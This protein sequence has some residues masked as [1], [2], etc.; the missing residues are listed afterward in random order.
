M[1]AHVRVVPTR[2]KALVAILFAALFFFG[3]QAPAAHASAE[4]DLTVAVTTKTGST[5]SG[6]N[7][8]AFPVVLRAAIDDPVQGVAVSGRPGQF[9]FT[10]LD[11]G[12]DYAIWFDAPS[13]AT[14]AFDQF[15]GGVTWIEDATYR[16]WAAGDHTLAVSLATNTNITGKVT[17]ASGTALSNVV[18]YPYRFDGSDWYLI[19]DSTC[20]GCVVSAKTNSVGTFVLRNLEP[21]SYRLEFAP[22][23][24][25]GYLTEFSG[26][27]LSLD[28]ATAIYAGLGTTS[29]VNASLLTGG[30]ITGKVTYQYLGE[31]YYA[32]GVTAVAYP[33][34]GGQVDTSMLYTS[35]ATGVSGSWTIPG[36]PPGSYVVNF[37]DT[38]YGTLEDFW[39]QNAQYASSATPLHIV[40][41]GSVNAGSTY[42]PDEFD[43]NPVHIHVQSSSTAADIEGAR[44]TVRAQDSAFSWEG[45]T[46]VSGAVSIPRIVPNGDFNVAV[47]ARDDQGVA[48]HHPSITVQDSASGPGTGWTILLAAASPFQWTSNP[49]VAESATKAGTTYDLTVPTT[50]MND[51]TG[52]ETPTY[53]TIQWLRDGKPIFGATGTTYQS[54][55]ADVGSILSVLVRAYGYGYPSIA[56]VATIGQ[57]TPGD[58]PINVV[59]PSISAPPVVAP[60]ATLSAN[61][62]TWNQSGLR[63]SFQWL[64]D[65]AVIPGETSRRYVLSPLDAV[66]NIKLEVTATRPG[67]GITTTTTTPI[68]VTKLPALKQTTTS[69]LTKPTT[70]IPVGSLS[71]KITS[72]VWTPAASSYTYQWLIDGDPFGPPTTGASATMVCDTVTQCQPEKVIQVRVTALRTGYADG[73]KTSVVRKGTLTPLIDTDGFA[74]ISTA[75]GVPLLATD[76][77]GVGRVLTATPPVL[78]WS[79]LA[80]GT[81]TVAYQWQSS[82]NNGVTWSNISGATKSTYAVK[83]DVL[84]RRVQVRLTVS[85][86]NYAS[87]VTFADA[88][89]ARLK[90]DLMGVTYPTL[91]INGS[92]DVTTTKWV[93]LVGNWPLSGVTQKYQWFSCAPTAASCS[94]TSSANPDWKPIAGATATSFTPPL[95]LQDHKLL[96]RV[97]GSKSGYQSRELRS[98]ALLLGPRDDTWMLATP[99]ISS[100]LVAGKAAIGR[101]LTGKPG[102]V[103]QPVTARVYRWETCVVCDGSDWTPIPGATSTTY[104]PT[105][106]LLTAYPSGKIRF[107]D[108]VDQP[109]PGVVGNSPVYPLVA[110]TFAPTSAPTVSGTTT[111]TVGP[112]TWPAATLADGTFQT[113]YQ[114]YNGTTTT[115]SGTN[116]LVSPALSANPVWVK[117]TATREG[118]TPLIYRLVARKGT[119]SLAPPALSGAVYGDTFQLAG[120]LPVPVTE[121]PPTL[122]YQWYSGSTAITGQTKATFMPSTS[123]VGKALKLRISVSS[124]FYNAYTVYSQAVT[125]A[126]HPASTPTPTIVSSTPGVYKPGAKLTAA[127]TGTPSGSTFTY[128]WQRS[129]DGVTWTNITTSSSYILTTSDPTKLIRVVVVAKKAGWVTSAAVP[130][131]A[132]TVAYTGTLA[133]VGPLKINGSGAVGSALS[134]APIWNTTGVT[135]TYKWLRNGVIL[136]GVTGTTFTPLSSS[137]G[138]EID[139]V[140]TASKPGYQTLAFTSNTVKVGE[141]VGPV[142]TSTPLT[143]SPSIAHQGMPVTVASAWS[144]DGVTLTYEWAA[145]SAPATILGT[146]PTFIPPDDI[147]Y[148][149]TVTATK[150]GYTTGTISRTVVVQP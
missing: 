60:G 140:A 89:I 44:V 122:K 123:Y 138:D 125:L 26:N 80:P 96:V 103:D 55:G 126:L 86:T 10:G 50:T 136:P 88:G 41:T 137:I 74:S 79:G 116:T 21:G 128:V 82:T 142:L 131:L 4:V 73:V 149:V 67:F 139:V 144:A 19:S 119:L 120:P 71:Y 37:V 65:D 66:H 43:P 35:P 108:E 1:T 14:T 68:A 31:Y 91:T 104:A 102:V 8:W 51:S 75:P 24:K 12:Q 3:L 62:G 58:A 52:L 141:A 9:L 145:L 30:K 2:V 95:S 83:S 34:I 40:G 72:G 107:V 94:P 13:S 134:V 85:S 84:N 98:P 106:D 57:V 17:N 132:V 130:S 78:D 49:S 48:L 47:E 39:S 114:W 23:N 11:A 77:V 105:G 99:T 111:Y 54:K 16:Q 81:Q 64:R 63:F 42:L 133:T 121:I 146:S 87:S 76:P 100:G 93:K 59:S 6:I 29:T 46:D 20:D 38:L 110:G 27:K 45:Y 101:V 135:V 36:L 28:T 69:V 22:N 109:L 97:I 53:T 129:T 25:T 70:G 115:G 124:P 5:L 18:V 117:V 15:Y 56:H 61:V 127:I 150:P 143:I 7:V 90:Q 148:T 113:T 92:D 118:Y 147:S 112:G 32:D 33:L